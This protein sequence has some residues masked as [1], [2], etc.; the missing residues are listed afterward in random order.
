MSTAI[1]REETNQRGTGMRK[2]K[3]V[4]GQPVLGF[5]DGRRLD[6]V[7]DLVLSGTDDSV[8]ALLVDEGGLLS[9]SRIVPFDQIRSFGR[10]A[11]VIEDKQAII[12]A[13]HSREIS[14]ILNRDEKLLGKKVV[15]DTGDGLGSISDMYFD[16]QT[17]RILGFEVSGGLIGD[18]ARGTS[19]LALEDIE[20]MGPDV[21][22]VRPDT[23]ED[24]ENQVG[25]LQ[26]A[27]NQA[28]D[29]IGQGVG[30]ARDRV[31][32]GISE[33]QPEQRLIGR[34]SGADV[35]DENGSIVVANGQRVRPA[36]VEW[37]KRTDNMDALTRAV[38]KGE[39]NETRQRAGA[40]LEEAGDNVGAVWDRFTHK[41]SQMRDENGRQVDEQYT[42]T[43]LAQIAD[44]I[45]RPAGKVI[46]DRQDNVILD[47]G[48]IIT[49]QAVQQ[50][51]DAGQLDALMASVVRSEIVLPPD[52]LRAEQPASATV[53]QA[54]G[55]AQLVDELEHKVQESERERAQREE[56]ERRE[57]EAAMQQREQ[58]RE[59]RSQQRQAQEQQREREIEQARQPGPGGDATGLRGGSR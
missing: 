51:H 45:G 44:I 55:N 11:V 19:Y 53:E 54:S 34:R 2:G 43:R 18:I 40:S 36:H 8:V 58:E 9:H 37:A 52:K 12:S 33:Q 20:R 15:T 59:Q 21:I 6:T 22:F 4:I 49:H 3:N 38:A 30:D 42:R 35:A 16:D 56:R 50:A 32:A 5:A 28:G 25:G 57:N 48:D 31:G 41:L 17:G 10:D 46:L 29:R 13:S 1:T 47:F 14:K 24:L 7:K 39:A 26:G 27:M 23:G